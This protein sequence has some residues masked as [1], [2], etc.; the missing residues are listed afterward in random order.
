M[1][2]LE[3]QLVMLLEFPTRPLPSH[4]APALFLHRIVVFVLVKGRGGRRVEVVNEGAA[5]REML[6]KIFT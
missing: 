6:L 5:G 3:M 4:P 2:L 1:T